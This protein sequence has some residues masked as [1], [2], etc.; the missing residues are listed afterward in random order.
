M[1]TKKTKYK[2]TKVKK[3]KSKKTNRKRLFCSRCA[4]PQRSLDLTYS[5]SFLSLGFRKFLLV[6]V[7]IQLTGKDQLNNLPVARQG[8]LGKVIKIP[9]VSI[10]EDL[11]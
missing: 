3:T 4:P 6:L 7:D 8:S 1:V 10:V 9:L 2:K 5:W 11:L